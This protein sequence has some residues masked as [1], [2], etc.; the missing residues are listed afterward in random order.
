M[1]WASAA[2]R[3]IYL[4]ARNEAREFI[5]ASLRGFVGA[6]MRVRLGTLW[7]QNKESLKMRSD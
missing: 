5:G 3:S 7:V 6:T 2:A 4:T 1:M